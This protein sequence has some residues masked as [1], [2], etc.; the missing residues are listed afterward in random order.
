MHE[1]TTYEKILRDGGI[2][3]AHRLLLLLGDIASEFPIQGPVVPSRRFRTSSV[4]SG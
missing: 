2:A 4:W 3:E 1:S